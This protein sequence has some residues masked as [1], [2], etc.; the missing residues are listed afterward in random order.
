[1]KLILEDLSK[2]K[3]FGSVITTL[4]VMG[5]PTSVH[6]LRVCFQT[7]EHNINLA[8]PTGPIQGII[9]TKPSPNIAAN[10]STET[11]S[12]LG[13]EIRQLN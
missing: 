11:D 9:D 6:E 5:I 13:R 1:M 10:N 3:I 12:P 8:N 2:N 7:Y 4:Y